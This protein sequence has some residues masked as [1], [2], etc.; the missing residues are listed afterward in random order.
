MK[1]YYCVR[2]MRDPDK[3]PGYIPCPDYELHGCAGCKE[4]EKQGGRGMTDS[5]CKWELNEVCVNDACPLCADFCP[6]I[7]THNVCKYEE[8][9]E[10]IPMSCESC[11]I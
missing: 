7:Y 11:K 4:L 3:N 8:L 9:V 10:D 1:T 5:K 6:L 2:K